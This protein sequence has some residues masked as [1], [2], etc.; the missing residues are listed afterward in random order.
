[1]TKDQHIKW[2]KDFIYEIQKCFYRDSYDTEALTYVINRAIQD[3]ESM[4]NDNGK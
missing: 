3:Y 4:R 2:T 1:M